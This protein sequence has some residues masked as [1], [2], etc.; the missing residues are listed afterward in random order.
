[1]V[2]KVGLPNFVAAIEA[3]AAVRALIFAQKIDLSSIILEG[4]SKIIIN[5]LKSNDAS[6]LLFNSHK[7]WDREIVLL[8]TLL[9]ILTEF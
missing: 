8:I 2:E 4:Y 3:L 7:I 6:L 5:K 1:M 9:D